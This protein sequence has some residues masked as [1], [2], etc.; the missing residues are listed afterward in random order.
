VDTSGAAA[1]VLAKGAAIES[2]RFTLALGSEAAI[3]GARYTILGAM[4]RAETDDDA[5]RW[6]EYLLYAAG[7]RFLW[8]VETDEGWQRT[9]VLDT[10]PGWDGAG[11][12]VLDG[13][14]FSQTSRYGA[15]VVAAVG[16]F[17]WRV[18][19]GDQVLVSEY[20]GGHV[21]LAAEASAEELTWSRSSML[22]LDQLR[23]WFGS[24]VHADVAPH[25]KYMDTARKF[26]WPLLI[27]NAIP[28]FLAPGNALPWALL[29]A[30]AII[31]PAYFL[32]K[33]DGD[34]S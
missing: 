7:R 5:S 3:D 32:D 17:N 24:H 34:A 19:A 16:S 8:L 18:S 27:I 1:E 15:R 22:P 29:G 20:T 23:A 33:L 14:N 26:L 4:R 28:A 11:H 31:L 9:E 21:R 13:V 10:W 25:P 6:S 2:V 30:A 12:A